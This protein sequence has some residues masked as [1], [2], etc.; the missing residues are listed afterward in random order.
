MHPPKESKDNNNTDDILPVESTAPKPLKTRKQKILSI[1]SWIFPPTAIWKVTQA[2][3]NKLLG[4]KISKQINPAQDEP[5]A[6]EWATKLRDKFIRRLSPLVETNRFLLPTHD[7]AKLDTFEISVNGGKKGLNKPHIIYFMGRCGFYEFELKHMLED[8]Y[9]L[10]AKTIGFNYRSVCESVGEKEKLA[11][12]VKDNIIDGIAQVQ[13]LI[14]SGVTPENIILYGDSYGAA[15]ATGVTDYFHKFGFKI[16]IFAVRTFSTMS[17][18][19]I[20]LLRTGKLSVDD[21]GLKQHS[22]AVL[23]KPFVKAALVITDCEIN[24]IKGYKRIPA[25]NKEYVL[26]RSRKEIRADRRDDIV[27]PHPESL[28]RALRS[29]RRK[30]K[31]HYRELTG[32]VPEHIRVASRARKFETKYP[33]TNGHTVPMRTL[34]NRYGV[35]GQQFFHHFVKRTMESHSMKTDPSVTLSKGR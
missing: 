2:G 35:N 15:V 34:K 1:A 13:R 12:H 29:E 24:N 5:G 8:A 21:D 31:K 18:E 7:G 20:G 11:T 3:M 17:N 30:E 14:K 10:D 28:H 27:V 32:S 26:V 19:L 23:A 33:E 9:L 16:S 4:A 6:R 22:L 25:A